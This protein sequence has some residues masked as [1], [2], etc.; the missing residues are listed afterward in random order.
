MQPHDQVPRPAR[1]RPRARRR[2]A[3]DRPLRR[4][5]PP[6]RTAAARL[7]RAADPE[8]DQSYFLYA[9]TPE[10][11]AMLRFPLGERDKA[12]TRALARE[13]GLAVA[14]KAD[15]QDICFV[16]QGRY[17][18]VIER[19][20][21]GAAQPGD[22]VHVD[23][24]VLGRHD[25]IIHYTVGQRRGLGLA[26]G[27]PLY[28]VRLDAGDGAASS[29]ARARRWRPARSRIADVNWLGDVPLAERR[30][31]DRGRRARALDRASRS[32]RCCGRPAAA[33]RSS[34]LAPEDG[35]SPGQACV[36]YDERRRR[37]PAC[38][39][40]ARSRAPRAT[41]PAAA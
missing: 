9:T 18:D 33:P 41:P 28:V 37:A 15:S 23:G 35:V 1:D 34:C 12:E 6:R 36:I 39:A 32:R 14:D 19:L 31:R 7:F 27:E 13:L 26:A 10:Q 17:S 4:E 25:G 5:P 2:R 3:G 24:R 22:I 11:L 20:K 40:A 21:P 30:R 29:S 8:R 38:S 16:P